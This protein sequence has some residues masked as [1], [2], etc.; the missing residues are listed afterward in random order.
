MTEACL[1][2]SRAIVPAQRVLGRDLTDLRRILT[3]SYFIQEE[4][5]KTFLI[6][7]SIVLTIAFVSVG[8]KADQPAAPGTTVSDQDQDAKIE[9]NMAK[10]S[11]E[12][13]KLAEAQKFCANL[14]KNR[15]G[16]MGVPVKIT[17]KDQ[18]VFL[19]CGGCVAKAK[20][21]PE[22]TLA[23]VAE[24]IKANQKK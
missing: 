12:D 5:M 8:S 11:P 21:N 9:A 4:S 19:C 13:R 3:H 18:P 1:E 10:L 14:T 16:A 23:T 2:S 7:S 17:I 6:A 22:K 24:L 20:A 15:L